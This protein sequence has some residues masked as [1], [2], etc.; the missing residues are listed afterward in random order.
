MTAS[1]AGLLD[2][3]KEVLARLRRASPALD[4]LVRAWSRYQG[5]AGDRLAAA[6]TYFGF[7]SFFPLLALAFSVLGYVVAVD[8][9]A[10]QQ[11]TSVLTANFPGLI[12]TE[13]GKIDVDQ[14]AAAKAGAGVLGLVGLL[15]AGLGWVDALRD[16]IRAIWHQPSL[17]GNV[18]VK[19]AKDVLV[20]AG[21]GGVLVLSLAV[22]GLTA[23]IAQRL[24]GWAGL[25]HSGVGTI[26]VSVL[27]P[28]VGLLVDV[29]LFLY[30]FVRL[31][32]VQTPWRRAVKGS[33][34]AAVGLEILKVVG[35]FLVAKTTKNPLYAS[36]AVVVGLLVWINL[37]SR[38]LLFCAA[39]TVTAPYHADVPPSGTAGTGPEPAGQPLVRG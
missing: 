26:V 9:H 39:W 5:D 2:R 11:V 21:L 8:P 30:L 22:S 1:P 4:H 37:V 19:K 10:H 13:P 32:R 28:L 12:G 18:V 31:P 20:L 16:A 6:V 7:L 3:A 24:L 35:A 33:V 25:A 23:T 34:F 36:F 17:T 29:A 38:F 27:G 15:L 14:I